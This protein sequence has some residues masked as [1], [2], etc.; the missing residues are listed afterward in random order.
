MNKVKFLSGGNGKHFVNINLTIDFHPV[1][2]RLFYDNEERILH[3]PYFGNAEY[4][5][6]LVPDWIDKLYHKDNFQKLIN[7]V[8]DKLNL[9][10]KQVFT[11][12]R[13]YKRFDFTKDTYVEE[14]IYSLNYKRYFFH[15]DVKYAIKILTEWDGLSDIPFDFGKG[16]NIIP[17]ELTT[18]LKNVRNELIKQGVLQ[19]YDHYQISNKTINNFIDSLKT[20]TK[21]LCNQ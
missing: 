12:S 21:Q 18:H 6:Y 5:S 2:I 15:T 8:C 11:D 3:N 16:K 4:K 9:A 19:D 14:Y 10:R 20:K 13:Y 1:I 7:N 17:E